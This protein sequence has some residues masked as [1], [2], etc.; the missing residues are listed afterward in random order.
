MCIYRD[1]DEEGV[2]DKEVINLNSDEMADEK[3]IQI[4]N[5]KL[6]ETYYSPND[7]VDENQVKG[8]DIDKNKLFDQKK[9]FISEN[10]LNSQKSECIKHYNSNII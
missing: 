7:N 3:G 10:D 6:S 9:D 4:N 8:N 2:E 1:D 5:G